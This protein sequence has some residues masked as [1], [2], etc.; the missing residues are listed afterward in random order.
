MK[1]KK[2]ATVAWRSSSSDDPELTFAVPKSA[3]KSSVFFLEVCFSLDASVLVSA[4]YL[5]SAGHGIIGSTCLAAFV[6]AFLGMETD[7][8]KK[9]EIPL[10]AP[11]NC[12]RFFFFAVLKCP[13]RLN[14]FLLAGL[15]EESERA[16]KSLIRVS[17]EII[18]ELFLFWMAAHLFLFAT[19]AFFQYLTAQLQQYKEFHLLYV[20]LQLLL[21]LT[22][23]FFMTTLMYA[24]VYLFAYW[25]YDFRSA[26]IFLFF[27]PF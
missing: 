2:T 27:I 11:T 7:R 21:W 13:Y 8:Q 3:S 23:H 20:L 6:E 12:L 26:Q 10:S 25:T 14:C 19:D 1:K 24:R 18:K 5:A 9:G 17:H 4:T 15:A 22:W 16:T